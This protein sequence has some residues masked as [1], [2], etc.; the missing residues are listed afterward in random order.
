M[1]LK[2]GDKP[3]GP[4]HYTGQELDGQYVRVKPLSTFPGL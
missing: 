3:D 1:G 2:K 4:V